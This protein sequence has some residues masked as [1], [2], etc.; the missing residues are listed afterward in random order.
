MSART[1]TGLMYLG[2][3]LGEKIQTIVAVIHVLKLVLN[4]KHNKSV[5]KEGRKIQI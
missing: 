2:S 1:I 4:K 5:Q 3:V